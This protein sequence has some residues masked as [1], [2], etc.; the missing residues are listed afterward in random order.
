MVARFVVAISLS[1]GWACPA[2]AAS[3]PDEVPARPTTEITGEALGELPPREEP[4]QGPWVLLAVPVSPDGRWEYRAFRAP[5]PEQ[6]PEGHRR[7]EELSYLAEI[8]RAW[9]IVRAP[10]F[11]SIPDPEGERWLRLGQAYEDWAR[12]HRE[13]ERDEYDLAI[14]ACL[15]DGREDCRTTVLPDFGTSLEGDWV[16]LMVYRHLAWKFPG[17]PAGEEAAARCE[18]LRAALEAR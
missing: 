7:M 13:R 8:A 17:H 9:T 16:A 1:L 15:E 4:P 12:F 11:P 10:R 14:K 5:T 6:D 3:D 2:L 18:S